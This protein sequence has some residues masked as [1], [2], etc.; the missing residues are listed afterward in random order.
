MVLYYLKGLRI[1]VVPDITKDTHIRVV[2]KKKVKKKA[3]Y[4]ERTLLR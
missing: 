2:H 1:E 4:K 3:R